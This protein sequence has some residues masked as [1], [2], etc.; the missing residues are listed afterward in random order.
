M[1]KA[2]PVRSHRW[3]LQSLEHF[4][5]PLAGA[6][7]LAGLSLAAP[8]AA[9]AQQDEAQIASAESAAPSSV[10]ADA[11]VVDWNME[12]LREGTNGW[13]CLPDNDATPGN[14]PWCVNEPWLSFL[15]AYVNQTEPEY[16]KL[17]IAYMLQGDTSVSNTDPHATEKT[18]EEDWVEDL[19]AHLMVL[20]PD[21]SLY[22]NLP[23]DPHSGGPWM[24]WPDTPYEH[25][26]IPVES[27]PE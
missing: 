20:V 26:M 12:V 16:G 21:R 14:D 5:A 11:R 25:I 1:S 23:T 9:V 17:G 2:C 19:G 7:L 8:S 18:N 4:A 3:N 15:H 6:A 10:S 27:V 22:D 24:M 13:T